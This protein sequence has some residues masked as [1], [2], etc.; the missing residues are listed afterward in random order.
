M[1]YCTAQRAAAVRQVQIIE[2]ELARA[3]A[4]VRPT[5]D[6]IKAIENK[7]R[8]AQNLLWALGDCGD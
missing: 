5:P 1:S 4:D 2:E 3:K 6:L 7:L 8:D